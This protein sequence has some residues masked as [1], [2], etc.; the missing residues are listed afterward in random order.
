MVVPSPDPRALAEFYRAP[1]GGEITHP[2]D[3]LVHLRARGRVRLGF[4]RAGTATRAW[5]SSDHGQRFHVDVTVDEVDCV[6]F[7][8]ASIPGDSCP[9]QRCVSVARV[10]P[11][12][13]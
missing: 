9:S 4:Q 6:P 10:V 11:L 7:G 3:H 5:S 13:C 8:L 2:D 12:A 1:V